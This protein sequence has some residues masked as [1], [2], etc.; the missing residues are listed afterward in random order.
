MSDEDRDGSD[1]ELFVLDTEGADIVE[2]EEVNKKSLDAITTPKHGLE[3]EDRKVLLEASKTREKDD[4]FDMTRIL[5]NDAI[6]PSPSEEKK[7]RLFLNIH[8]T[9]CVIHISY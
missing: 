5:T 4:V 8:N 6:L 9:G 3:K 7:E 2:M 1:G